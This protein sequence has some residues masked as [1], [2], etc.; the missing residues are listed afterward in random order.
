MGSPMRARTVVPSSAGSSSG[1]LCVVAVVSG[2]GGVGGVGEGGSGDG[3]GDGGDGGDG[4]GD[5]GDGGVAAQVPHI[6]GQANFACLPIAFLFTQ[7]LDGMVVVP[8]SGGSGCPLHVNVLLKHIPQA[9][10]QTC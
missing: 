4:E 1:S 2:D 9:V 10:G 8:Q 6:T 3:E 5:G 7:L